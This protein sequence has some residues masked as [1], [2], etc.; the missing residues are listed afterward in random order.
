MSLLLQGRGNI[1]ILA[2]KVLM[3][4]QKSHNNDT[5]SKQVDEMTTSPL[6]LGSIKSES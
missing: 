2:R 6:N 4:E 3:D 1:T 5:G